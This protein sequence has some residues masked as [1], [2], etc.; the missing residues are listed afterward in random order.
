M[1]EKEI[2]EYLRKMK[3]FFISKDIPSLKIL[4]NELVRRNFVEQDKF[5]SKLSLLA[6]AFFKILGKERI[7][8]SEKWFEIKDA[9]VTQLEH[10]IELSTTK[11]HLDA[12]ISDL[13][14]TVE[15]FD[16]ETSAYFR[17]V[18]AHGRIKHATLLYSF[19]VSIDKAAD[20]Y[21]VSSAELLDY[22]G[23]TKTHDMF[24][25]SKEVFKRFKSIEKALE[26]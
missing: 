24:I 26:E 17:S 3:D 20:L 16:L 15:K 23:G 13:L 2:D 22:V 10:A 12:L 14:N 21:D 11:E 1:E 7:Q 19:G 9:L 5:I 4:S 8:K 6:Y 18:I 25:P